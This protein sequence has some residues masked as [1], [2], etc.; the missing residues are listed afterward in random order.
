MRRC[1][2]SS[3]RRTRTTTRKL[4]TFLKYLAVAGL[5][6][7]GRSIEVAG[8]TIYYF[9][10]EKLTGHHQVVDRLA[11]LQQLGALGGGN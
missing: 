1:S 3:A 10:D 8:L 5:P 9:A 6:A 7:T 2:T 4:R 11:V